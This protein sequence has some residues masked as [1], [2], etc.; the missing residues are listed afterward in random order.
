MPKTT[1]DVP[2]G[3]RGDVDRPQVAD[4]ERR[5]PLDVGRAVV[6]DARHRPGRLHV[7]DRVDDVEDLARTPAPTEDDQ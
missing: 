6:Q 7:I 5:E 4:A 3:S 2:A 1:A